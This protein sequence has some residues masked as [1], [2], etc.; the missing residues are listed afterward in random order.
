MGVLL[1]T[2]TLMLA[3]LPY[4]HAR[5]IIPPTPP[6]PTDEQKADV[7]PLFG[8]RS[9]IR[10]AVPVS[11]V[12]CFSPILGVIISPKAELSLQLAVTA[13]SS[14]QA[15]ALWAPTSPAASQALR[16]LCQDASAGPDRLDAIFLLGWSIATAG[17]MIRVAAFRAL[18]KLFTYELS[19]SE[20]HRLVTSGP[21]AWV[22]HPGYT[23]LLGNAFGIAVCAFSGGSWIRRCG[24]MNSWL[25]IAVVGACASMWLPAPAIFALRASKEDE[26]M[27][28]EY[29]KEWD[30]WRGR[31]RYRLIPGV[32]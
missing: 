11:I 4:S 29:G 12:R 26:M 17:S 13:Y 22:R 20:D 25:G 32:W 14:G 18:D 1:W 10:L 3:S 9:R 7:T 28:R 21:Y 19:V 6:V 23:G 24:V 5:T 16:A 31:V 27:K 2:S 8:A 30:E 15:A